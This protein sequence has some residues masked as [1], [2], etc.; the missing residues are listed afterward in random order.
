MTK[1]AE[2]F[3][4]GKFGLNCAK[5][6]WKMWQGGNH[7]SGIESYITF[8]RYV[9]KLPLDYSKW[10]HWEK[11]A[12]HSGPRLIHE[13]FCIISDRP[14]KLMV[15]D[16]NHPHC[17][18]GPFCEWADGSAIY[19]INGI[20]IPG[21]IAKTK[22][23]EFTK[24]MILNETNVDYRR[25]IIQKIG[26]ERTIELLGAETIDR[27]DSP[28]GGQYELIAIDYDG[29]GEKRPFLKM[30]NPSVDAWH[31]EGCPPNIRTVKDAICYR[32]GLSV[33]EEPQELS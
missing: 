33:F 3:G 16:R 9:A 11:S 23:E 5:Q 26:I 32:N 17:F 25:S 28:V 30:K 31:I 24:E 29:R 12:I 20:R 22:R 19:S 4:I 2:V 13:K 27:Y 14:R 15:N 1:I 18:D 7:W 21:W 10:D 6:A 8:F